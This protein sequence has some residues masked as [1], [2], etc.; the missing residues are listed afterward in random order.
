MTANR[1]FP[2]ELVSAVINKLPEVTS[3]NSEPT[4][5]S[6][7]RACS[8]VHRTWTVFAQELLFAN[9]KCS[10]RRP[11]TDGTATNTP[12]K[13]LSMLAD[14]LQRLPPTV[15]GHVRRLTLQALPW[16][17]SFTQADMVDPATL[18]AVLVQLP[19]LRTL[20]LH[21]V[22]P[23][24]L[25]PPA[26]RIALPAACTL[27]VGYD[28]GASAVA[29]MPHRVLG[30]FANVAAVRLLGG[31][32]GGTWPAFGDPVDGA[33]THLAV[34]RLELRN[35]YVAP[36]GIFDQ[37]AR[38]PTVRT[39]KVLQLEE[40]GA[41]VLSA[42]QELINCAGPSLRRLEF[43]TMTTRLRGTRPV[44]RVRPT[45]LLFLMWR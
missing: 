43:E 45:G 26:S 17:G 10:F 13:T 1:I 39:L 2:A 21:N 32:G 14:A 30:C 44:F 40:V 24:H 18:A 31:A 9:L 12:H 19:E 28:A 5:R 20:D 4:L 34:E 29:A 41:G 33:L 25:P 16:A 11:P 6:A 3:N 7:L 37:L 42:L 8:L 38:S 35:M 22:V 27:V 23:A 15:R 36:L